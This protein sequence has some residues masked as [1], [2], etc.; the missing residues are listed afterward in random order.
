[1]SKG[2]RLCDL[3]VGDT[4]WIIDEPKVTITEA[5]VKKL[6]FFTS[7][8]IIYT[9]YQTYPFRSA[10][11]GA[12]RAAGMFLE[13]DE[14]LEYLQKR[15]KGKIVRLET[16]IND[17]VSEFEHLD[18]IHA[19]T[20]IPHSTKTPSMKELKPGDSVWAVKKGDIMKVE[21]TKI[22]RTTDMVSGDITYSII[23]IEV[24]G[25][26][27][28]SQ[29]YPNS[30]HTFQ[31]DYFTTEEQ[32]WK[33]MLEWKKSRLC[34]VGN[35]IEALMKELEDLEKHENIWTAKKGR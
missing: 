18:L 16:K 13:E 32:A 24:E 15:V 11:Q 23:S 9:T 20:V 7:D 19:P 5:T 14:A 25:A 1:M 29:A 3:S 33:Y 8:T 17:L 10:Y 2:K 31:L 12:K 6:L 21:E 28:Q 34:T 35:K 22:R 27:F 4:V 30:S 26:N